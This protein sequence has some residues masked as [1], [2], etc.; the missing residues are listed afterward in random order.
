M[1]LIFM[2]SF[3]HYSSLTSP[4]GKWTTSNG[5]CGIV[6]QAQG[7]GQ[8][9]IQA[10]AYGPQKQFG[11]NYINVLAQA[12]VICSG[13]FG[14]G[15]QWLLWFFDVGTD[16]IGIGVD[17]NGTVYAYQK[18]QQTHALFGTSAPGGFPFNTWVSVACRTS[19][20][21]R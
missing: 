11:A 2:D 6:N 15:V 7:Q 17:Q 9:Q 18:P 19:E 1:S 4:N 5:N 16:I 21:R 10:G 14:S 13:N 20:E 12:N 3:G 8:M